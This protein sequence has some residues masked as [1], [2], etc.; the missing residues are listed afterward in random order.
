MALRRMV[1]HIQR[2]AVRSLHVALRS[3]VR[4]DLSAGPCIAAAD[5][6]HGQASPIL[7][8]VVAVGKGTA[9]NLG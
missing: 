3:G 4:L 9:V 5:G 2:N 1:G 6:R 8:R 7:V